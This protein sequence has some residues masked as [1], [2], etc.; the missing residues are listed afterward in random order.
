MIT[1]MEPGE[2][3]ET[4]DAAKHIG[5]KPH[6]LE[7][8]RSTKRHRIPYIKA[9]RNVRYRRRDFDAW[10]ASRMDAEERAA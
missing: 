7:I 1:R 6:T 5:V 3:L 2:L 10:L 9:G 8:W 4:A